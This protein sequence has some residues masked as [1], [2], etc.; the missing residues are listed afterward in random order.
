MNNPFPDTS[1]PEALRALIASIAEY[2]MPFGM[3]GPAHY[4]PK[5]VILYDLPLEYLGWFKQNGFPKGKLGAYLEVLWEL[6]SNGLD[7]LFDPF[8]NAHGGRMLGKKKNQ[9]KKFDIE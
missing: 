9:S 2:Y 8:R 5:G 7:T 4:P 3:F 1:D 6:K